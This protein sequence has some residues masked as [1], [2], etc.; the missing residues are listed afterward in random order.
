MDSI[1]S[2][3]NNDVLVLNKSF[4]TLLLPQN[5]SCLHVT[6]IGTPP[7]NFTNLSAPEYIFGHNS[8]AHMTAVVANGIIAVAMTFDLVGFL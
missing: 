7:P 8:T 1:E 5:L 3:K 2:Y 6:L 4:F